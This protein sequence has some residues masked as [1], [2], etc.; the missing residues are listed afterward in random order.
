SD[1]TPSVTSS[2]PSVCAASGLVVTYVTAGTCTLTAQT[3]ASANFAAATGSPQI[4]TIAQATP[5]PTPSISN[6]PS[7]P[8][9][10]PGGGF[11][12][13]LNATNSDGTQSLTSV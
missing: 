11:I 7:S 9:W 2:S 8:T 10:S 3:M 12:A 5:S 1:G 6:V 4:F 13:V